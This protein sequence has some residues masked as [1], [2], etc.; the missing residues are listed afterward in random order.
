MLEL[1]RE[2]VKGLVESLA[3]VDDKIERSRGNPQNYK[4]WLIFIDSLANVKNVTI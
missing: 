2:G 3:I 1:V 4:T